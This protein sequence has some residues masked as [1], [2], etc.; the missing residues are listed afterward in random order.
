MIVFE[1]LLPE[2][3]LQI[4]DLLANDERKRLE[5]RGMTFELTTAAKEAL[6]QEGYDPVYGARP[7]R[8]VIQRRIENALSKRLLAGEFVEGDCIS[9]DYAAGEYR[10]SR[11]PN[12]F[13]R[14]AA[15]PREEPVTV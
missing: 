8:R 4:V 6:V 5:E 14:P 2:Q 12:A 13:Q 3:L 1:P 9:V 10:F 11:K 15:P 7:L